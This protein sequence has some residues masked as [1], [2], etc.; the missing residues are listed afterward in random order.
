MNTPCGFARVSAA[1][2]TTGA[3]TLAACVLL[4][5]TAPPAVAAT[6]VVKA[7]VV[8]LVD[9]H[10]VPPSAVAG[11]VRSFV[12]DVPWATLQPVQGGPLVHPNPID[13][14]IAQARA[15]GF[16]LKLR[17]E[18]GIAAPQWAKTLDGPPMTFYYTDATVSSA[19]TV[20]GTVG[21]FWTPAFSAAYAALQVRLAA[22][23]DGVP[24]IR[25]TT[26]TQ[27]QT[28]FAETYLRNA[29]DPRNTSALL[30]DGF[31]RAGDD[32]CHAAQLQAHRVWKRTRSEVA[33]NPYQ[34]IAP[35]GA[36]TQDTAYTLGQMDGC[37]QVLARMC[38]L[39]NF[40][41]SSDR[42]ADPEY[43][44]IYEHMRA[45]GAPIDF[46]TAT[47]AKIGD[48]AK[49]ITFA[50]DL[51]ASSVELPSGYATWPLPTLASLAARFGP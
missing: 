10:H 32:Q 11:V 4:A 38:V 9:R 8:G 33:F 35:T 31:T 49:A 17:V 13:A 34:G 6:A 42:I 40:S 47:A 15:G 5:P 45:L 36:V 30:A 21:R 22:A 1:L 23:Y 7:P 51:G 43:G 41:L 20:A 12:V 27:C 44:A 18:A 25:E 14:A 2:A 29:K 28:I 50:S 26:V 24:E 19:G 37:R 48:Y 3:A 39:A 16:A 46:Q